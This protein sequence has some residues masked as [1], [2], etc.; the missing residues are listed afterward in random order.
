MLTFFPNAFDVLSHQQQITVGLVSFFTMRLDYFR[1]TSQGFHRATNIFVNFLLNTL[2]QC[3]AAFVHMFLGLLRQ[4]FG[5]QI[6]LVL[7]LF[8]Q[9]F[10]FHCIH[11]YLI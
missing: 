7:H 8:T 10:L 5:G 6:F 3:V 2:D 1:Q 11:K 4:L 9:N